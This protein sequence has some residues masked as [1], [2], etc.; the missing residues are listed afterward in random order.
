MAEVTRHPLQSQEPLKPQRTGQIGNLHEPSTAAT[1]HF[2]TVV[3]LLLSLS[4]LLLYLIGYRAYQSDHLTQVPMFLKQLN[5]ELFPRDWFFEGTGQLVVRKLYIGFEVLL[6]QVLG[7][8]ELVLFS[9]Y[10]ACLFLSVTGLWWAC[11]ELK[12]EIWLVAAWVVI[13]GYFNDYASLSVTMMFDDM[14]IPRVYPYTACLLA[15]P[16]ILRRWNFIPGLILG[17]SGLMQGAPSLQFLP[18]LILWIPMLRGREGWKGMLI[19]PLAFLLGYWPQ[20]LMAR[21]L[22]ASG[23]Y[24]SSE[25]IHWLAYVRHPH[26]MLPLYFGWEEYLHTL[27]L[28]LLVWT[29]LRLR[30]IDGQ[31]RKMLHLFSLMLAALLASAFFIE[32]I[33]VA[34]WIAFQPMRMVATF[35]IIALFF[36]AEHL[37]ELIKGR[38]KPLYALR[39]LLLLLAIGNTPHY[40]M[41]MAGFIVL[42][43]IYSISEAKLPLAHHLRLVRIVSFLSLGMWLP[44]GAARAIGF[45]VLWA[46]FAFPHPR[47]LAL[48][49]RMHVSP[50]L[51]MTVPA[52]LMTIFYGILLLWPFKDWQKDPRQWSA[53]ENWHYDLAL[54]WT[55]YPFPDEALEMAGLWALKN[56][57][58]DSL[59]IIPPARDNESF[60][61]WSQRSAVFNVKMFPYMQDQWPLWIERYYALGGVMDP[62]KD[63]EG[64][65]ILYHDE[66]GDLIGI[67]YSVLS[68]TEM[69]AIA[70]RYEADYIVSPC[71]ALRYSDTLQTVAGPF[72]SIKDQLRS[73][74]REAALWIFRVPPRS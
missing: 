8:I 25:F 65:D 43:L 46:L 41:V 22:V 49:S 13:F 39:A 63:K 58:L 57:D 28:I 72:Y 61:I 11:R 29:R 68:D 55:V 54:R 74:P 16:M 60:H 62:Q 48:T 44:T 17:I 47:T 51:A 52:V 37:W 12:K 9:Q 66:S 2:L 5:P 33:P 64:A 20:A 3:Y 67:M 30:K 15:I 36:F 42:D 70:H 73:R 31:S 7:S 38:H 32:V 23:L 53:L 1:R 71:D 18:I 56:T 50:R 21:E 26:H 69:L 19:L 45:P 40:P 4:T 6:F 14:M 27:A 59:F 35:R 10:I 34:K 24:S